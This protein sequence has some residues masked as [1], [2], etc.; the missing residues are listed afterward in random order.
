MGDS[1]ESADKDRR[2]STGMVNDVQGGGSDGNT[3]WERELGS[4][5]RGC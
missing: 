5:R 1:G 4:Y 2:D 3:L